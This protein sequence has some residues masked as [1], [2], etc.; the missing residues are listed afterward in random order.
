MM[1]ENPSGC[2]WQEKIKVKISIFW[3]SR[4]QPCIL[5]LAPHRA[6]TLISHNRT[7]GLHYSITIFCY[8]YW[9][10]PQFACL[11][12]NLTEE[13]HWFDVSI[14][15]FAGVVAHVDIR[16]NRVRFDKGV[17]AELKSLGAKVEKNFT[18]K[19][20]YV[21]FVIPVQN[22]LKTSSRRQFHF[23]S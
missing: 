17:Q 2:L 9:L 8:D 1:W 15:W 6:W 13:V 16:I 4:R 18:K 22:V 21:T 20:N 7:N 19:V 14:Y 11:F 23:S 10:N 5:Y 12:Y 3:T